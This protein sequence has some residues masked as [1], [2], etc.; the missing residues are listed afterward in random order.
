MNMSC[1]RLSAILASCLLL[2]SSTGCSAWRR[3]VQ[4]ETHGVPSVPEAVLVIYHVKPGAEDQL[5]ELL[6]QAWSIYRREQLV[7]DKPHLLV[8]TR[9]DAQNFRF[10]EVFSWVSWAATEHPPDAVNAILER[11]HSLCE[12]RGGN[13]AVEFR[14]AQILTP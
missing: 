9:E 5:E 2:S 11:I 12:A 8:R 7:C 10:I 14:E 1:K 6:K 3:G 4:P 13:V